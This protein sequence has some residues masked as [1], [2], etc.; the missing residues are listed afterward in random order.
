LLVA[1]KRTALIGLHAQLRM[2]RWDK[3]YWVCVHGDWRLAKQVVKAPLRKFLTAKGERRVCVDSAG[4]G[5]PAHTSFYLKTRFE[6]YALLEAHLKTGRTHQIRV[7]LAH[8]GTPVVG[9]AK[10]G[11]FSLDR[12][13]ARS[14][15][16]PGLKRMFL[17]AHAL[18][19]EHPITKKQVLLK[20]PLPLEC[21]R[22]L[23]QLM[24]I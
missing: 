20:A 4:I 12:V 18:G 15:A 14:G 8:V 19:F 9:D 21:E 10:Y 22:F 1:K 6:G 5:Q 2:H 3:R 13:L 23:T 11:N 17:H 24:A 7:H 16:S